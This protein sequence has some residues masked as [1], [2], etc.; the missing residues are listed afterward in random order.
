M[1]IV[2]ISID[3]DGEVSV[4]QYDSLEHPSPSL[5]GSAVVETLREGEGNGEQTELQVLTVAATA[6]TYTL[7]FGDET[8]DEIA[9]DASDSDV[10]AALEALDGISDS[11]GVTV[12][13]GDAGVFT[14]DFDGEG[15]NSDNVDQLIVDELNYDESVDL[16]GK[17][18]A[19]VT[20]TDGDGDVATDS[21]DIGADIEFQ[22][23]GPTTSMSST[24]NRVTLDETVGS[25][26]DAP[27]DDIESGDSGNSDPF[28]HAYGTPIGAVSDVDMVDTITTDGEDDEGATT[29]VSLGIVGGDGS[30]SGL[31][32]T[33]GT[34]INLFEETNGDVTGRAG[35]D[36]GEVIFAIS[37]DGDGEVSVAQYDSLEHDPNS[38][39]SHDES[40][41][42]TD[43]LDAVVTVTDG[44]GDVATASEEI[45]S[46]IVFQDD[47]PTASISTTGNTVTLDETVADRAFF[48]M[49]FT[50][51]VHENEARAPF[52]GPVETYTEDLMVLS[53]PFGPSNTQHL[54]LNLFS[55][56]GDGLSQHSGDTAKFELLSGG[57]F[58]LDGFDLLQLCNTVPNVFTA[59][60]GTTNLGSVV[61]TSLTD[62]DYLAIGTNP[63]FDGI[64]SFTWKM[65]TGGSQ[66]LTTIDN[67]AYSV[68]LPVT[69]FPD[70]EIVIGNSDPFVGL[71][72]TPMGAVS[73]V[74]MVDTITDE[75]EDEEGATTVVS[76]NVLAVD[77]GLA[78][79]DGTT[80]NLFEESN[81]D[82]TGRAGG[83][84]G[85]VI[86]AISID[87]DG[88]VSVAQYDSLEHDPNS[89]NSH[90]ESVDLTDK[91]D[92]VVTVTDGDGDVATDNVAIGSS[93]SFQDD[94]PTASMTL[95]GATVTLDETVGSTTDTP[96]DDIDSG[97]SD[98]FGDAYGTPIGAV[99]DVD[100]VDT[101][102][103]T[104]EDEE[105]ATTVV[106]L[107]VLALDSGLATTDGTTINLYE[108]NNGDVTGRA[109]SDSGEVIFAISIDADGEVSVAQYD[110]LEHAPA[111]SIETIRQGEGD[112]ELTELQ[113]LTVTSQG[114]TYTL[115]YGG[116]PPG[117]GVTATIPFDATAGEIEALLISSIDDI[118]G[119][120]GV[121]VTEGAAGVFTIDF[122]GE[123]FNSDNVPELVLD[124]SGLV[125]FDESVD[126]TG[127]LDAV[128]T[129]TDGD[130]DVATDSKEI[131]SSISFQD[132]EPT[133]SMTL[134]GNTVTLDE[135]VG[136]TTDTPDDDIDSGNPDPFG[137]RYS[138]GV[139]LVWKIQ[140]ID[141][142]RFLCRDERPKSAIRDNGPLQGRILSRRQGR[143]G[144][145]GNAPHRQKRYDAVSRNPTSGAF[146]WQYPRLRRLRPSIFPACL[147]GSSRRPPGCSHCVAR[148]FVPSR[149]PRRPRRSSCGCV[150]PRTS[151]LAMSWAPSSRTGTMALP[152]SSGTGRAG[153]GSR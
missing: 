95:T 143:A 68:P 17:L 125:N 34:T 6:G 81:G 8:T 30:D 103:T 36:S 57:V 150:R 16:A 37:I 78:T 147:L 98:P 87:A 60:S 91:L 25:T 22:D 128:V 52:N 101:T 92:A 53:A 113:L 116:Q 21:V 141:L 148:S 72:G 77:S 93:I 84:S 56:A 89:P 132:D 58:D 126:L 153:S 74:D 131:G 64:T 122:D 140:V 24:G 59:F 97:N 129:V 11:G 70:D 33:D 4:A 144:E 145:G 133:A 38:P 88:E 138:E 120:G 79:T 20:A 151:S 82:V 41:D 108:E 119:N 43:K 71:Y 139:G 75:G 2:P 54:H 73:N 102:T 45:G 31:A 136:S 1:T 19:V 80:I 110:S 67:V 152:G 134:T 3:G 123:G 96:D 112:G 100:M 69:D 18:D 51:G 135:T 55:A 86:F 5:N 137:T 29:V 149:A 146:P 94:G 117:G 46:S 66:P 27:D 76:L 127:K 109:G 124:T 130:G 44:D 63:L 65:A 115:S 61:I 12:T 42:L 28:D 83:D 9:F 23:D 111:D 49:D 7:S 62:P 47:G 90:D 50:S 40:I 26:T 48:T 118:D 142:V 39:N 99:S 32:T 15:F 10:E 85:E 121:T 105:G 114:G 107:N 106:S 35:G 14:I 13:E 104:G